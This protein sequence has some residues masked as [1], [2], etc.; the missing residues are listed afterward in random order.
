MA[1]RLFSIP[2]SALCLS[3]LVQGH[4]A[5]A[6]EPQQSFDRV[7][8]LE[9][10]KSAQP[11]PT[12]LFIPVDTG[13]IS[14]EDPTSVVASTLSNTNVE[15]TEPR[16]TGN[17]SAEPVLPAAG[18]DTTT[19]GLPGRGP[20]RLEDNS[21][22]STRA[23]KREQFELKSDF[24]VPIEGT[25]IIPV[26]DGSIKENATT[27]TRVSSNTEFP[28]SS[29]HK[30]LVEF[31]S[32]ESGQ[33]HYYSCTAFAVGSFHLATSG[34]CVYNHDP[35]NNGST[36]DRS[37]ATRI[38]TWAGQ[39]DQQ[40][41]FDVAD[42]PFGIAQGVY[43][44]SYTG[45][46]NSQD[47]R[48]NWGIVTLDRRQGDNTG[49]MG[50]DASI[51]PV[52]MNYSGYPVESPFVPLGTH[53]QYAGFDSNN[54]TSRTSEQ[55]F[56]NA[57]LY[58]GNSGSPA[59]RF[60]DGSRHAL[61]INTQSDR[62]GNATFT[63]L[64]QGK[65]DDISRWR[66]EDETDRRPIERPNL[67]EYWF[68]GAIKD[69]TP[70]VQ[71]PGGN[72]T[73]DYNIV[74]IGFSAATNTILDFYLSIDDFV[75]SSDVFL[76]SLSLGTIDAYSFQDGT[77][78]LQ[79]PV[80]TPTGTY[81][82]GWIARTSTPEYN[83]EDNSVV[84]TATEIR[85]SSTGSCALDI[86][87][88][89]GSSSLAKEIS[90]NGSQ[91]HSICPVGDNDW[92]K[93]SLSSESAALLE[94]AGSSG[95]TR[96]WLY[97]AGLAELEFNDDGG[98]FLFSRIQRS[99]DR[100][101]LPA[102]T[103]FIQIDE[104]FDNDEIPEYTISLTATPCSTAP[105]T[106]RAEPLRL[107]FSAPASVE[108]R[109]EAL[110][111]ATNVGASPLPPEQSSFLEL[112]GGNVEIASLA[113]LDP[114]E[115]ADLDDQ[116]HLL[117][118]FEELLDS[119][120]RSSLQRAG[121]NVLEYISGSTYLVALSSF[122]GASQ[123]ISS[124]GVRW[125]AVPPPEVKAAALPSDA[126]WP[127]HARNSDGSLKVLVRL[128]S[129]VPVVAATS[130]LVRLGAVKLTRVLGLH[131]LEIDLP[132]D[133]LGDL[134]NLDEISWVE[135]ALPP[136]SIHNET[137][138]QRVNADQVRLPPLSLS[139]E[140]ISIGIWDGGAVDQHV[141]FSGRLTV[142]NQVL[143][144]SHATHVAGTAGGAGQ[145]RESARGMAPASDLFSWDWNNDMTELRGAATSRLIDISNHSYG[146]I[147]G[148]QYDSESDAWIDY[149]AN[150]FGLY[151]SVAAQI[152]DIVYDTG[153]LV[154]KSAGND[155]NDGP[156]CNSGGPRCDGDFTS[157]GFVGNSKNI[158]SVCALTDSDAMTSFSSWG[159]TLDGRVKPD[160]CANGSRLESTGLG[161]TYYSSSGTSMSSPSA[162][163]TAALLY[164]LFEARNGT[165][166]RAD[167]MKAI[168]IAGARDLANPG[169]DFSTGWGIIDAV[170]SSDLINT[171]GY[172]LGAVATNDT[173]EIE[174]NHGGGALKATLVWTD[175]SASPSAS[176]ALVNDLDL[177]LVSPSGQVF[178]PWVLDA[179][180]P[181]RA[182][183]R[184]INRVDNVEQVS[185]SNAQAG[186]WKLRVQGSSVPLGPQ[187][188]S[189][190]S[191]A[192]G[193]TDQSAVQSFVVFN[194]GGETLT[195]NNIAASTPATW[196]EVTPRSFSIEPGQTS[197]VNVY[198]DYEA[199]PPGR[200]SVKLDVTSD[201][202]DQPVL[203]DGV[204]VIVDSLGCENFDGDE[205]CDDEDPD[206]DNDGYSDA[207]ELAAGSSPKDSQS[208]PAD[209][210]GDFLP[211]LTDPDDDND[212]YTDEEELAFG[213]NPLDASDVP[214]AAGVSIH[215][216]VPSLCSQGK[217]ECE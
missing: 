78:S 214:A 140:S 213:S 28:W 160:L 73:I 1:K 205:L 7:W 97:D 75:A 129:D 132:R 51:N 45:W 166:P 182:A 92:L 143:A 108:D 62:A 71:D 137:A 211:D 126:E 109:T 64:T 130:N 54:V 131:A 16:N 33:F 148:W 118:N 123:R 176:K 151:S 85:I 4:L 217:I 68:P 197:I 111:F 8:L 163:G 99:C 192:L 157:I 172:V 169:P 58:G 180:F 110:R 70:N 39:T 87:E 187:E 194:D 84:V 47:Q 215:M 207:D 124:M 181:S 113:R 81:H 170:A 134:V 66:T 185:L 61:G 184:G 138:A 20:T 36:G 43:M 165:A 14:T 59:W 56:V 153:V 106:I 12:T 26:P 57:L 212:G 128:H 183:G 80:G 21:Y 102:G 105:P 5:T 60:L 50:L 199:A 173:T 41:P 177:T 11:V 139:G 90:V 53:W 198:V 107:D 30:L 216:L 145:T 162:A 10:L 103:Y 3:C 2:A 13:S 38:W 208:I 142:V 115:I 175:P 74:N 196:L 69:V 52:S 93:F 202:P 200:S 158:L 189:V 89:N 179:S 127:D 121:I 24:A 135:P 6:Q 112:L 188:F 150:G 100:D 49:W 77:V 94:T 101:P 104:F 210:D 125:A 63:R 136:R 152:D 19:A 17:S 72:L 55:F 37:W 32:S 120:E 83:T 31:R 167:L 116:R 186:R 119:Q 25:E 141:D 178:Q 191:A 65:L 9:T 146:Y 23:Q 91:I 156:D 15:E 204:F 133:A 18:S 79:V 174:F 190:V 164:E 147:V 98:S 149:G 159:P 44:R 195:V 27:P 29:I 42:H 34:S 203:R 40:E 206:D 88:P 144:G 114:A 171:D 117:M 96:M 86:Y 122:S 35:D 161:N 168:L 46:T 154:F 82:V 201:D 193:G 76:G 67:I 209:N 155:R 95:D 22:A 48:Q